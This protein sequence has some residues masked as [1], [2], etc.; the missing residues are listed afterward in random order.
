MDILDSL[1]WRYAT[2]KFDAEKK[3]TDAQVD[4]VL[5]AGNLAATSYGLQ[6]FKFLVIE[7][8]ELQERLIT[9]SYGQRQVADASHVIV[10]ATRGDVDESYIS[11]YVDQME[12]ERGLDGGALDNYKAVMIGA[13]SD[14]T[15][16]DMQAWATKQAYIALGT[17]MAACAAMQIDAC[18]MEGFVS[19]EY[20]EILGLGEMKLS[21]AV[22]LPI[23]YRAG[24]DKNSQNKKIRQPLNEIVVKKASWQQA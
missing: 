2:K 18:P 9:S 24:D 10:I 19:S 11:K 3:L 23:G 13:V 7:N 20:N 17:M 16:D 12:S 15:A 1:R 8:K 21:A 4:G 22:V 6:P 5:E 14:M